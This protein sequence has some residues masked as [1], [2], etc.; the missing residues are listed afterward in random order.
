MSNGRTLLRS[1]LV[2]MTV[3]AVVAPACAAHA[4]PT[5]AEIQVQIDDGNRKVELI[6]E[7]YNK[8]NGDLAATQAALT[9]LDAKLRPIQAQMAAAQV[10]VEQVAVSAYK[11]GSHLR[12]LSVVLGAGSSEGFVD[13]LGTLQQISHNQ[14]IELDTFTAAKKA[15]DAE[16]Q[17][18]NTLLAT[19]QTQKGELDTRRKQIEADIARLDALQDKVNAE[20]AAKK[21]AAS[22]P[23]ATNPGPPPAVSGQAGKAVSYAWAQLGK[24]YVWGAAGPNTF[25]CSGL[26][27][28]AWKAAGVTLP[29]N[30]AQQ[31][32]KVKHISRSQLAPGDLVFYNGLGHVGIY[33]GNNQIIHAPNSRTVVKVAPIDVDPLYGYGRPG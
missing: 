23:P 20:E 1:L 12:T 2:G 29:H 11:T 25:D 13:Q 22:N 18:L 8:V 31:W 33:I 9:D 5:A 27:M 7:E 3:A 30:A 17:R 6:V 26:T 15:Y 28:M 24:K 19:Q 32:G 10:N 16:Q 21:K 14:Q 4:D